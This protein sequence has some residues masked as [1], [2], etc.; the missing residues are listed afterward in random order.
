MRKLLHIIV[1][2][3]FL[4][5]CTMHQTPTTLDL[6]V[7]AASIESCERKVVH[8]DGTEEKFNC[9]KIGSDGFSTVFGTMWAS[10]LAWAVWPWP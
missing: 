4:T 10:L 5:A 3:T 9:E 1:L 7:G 6:T 8:A 2:T